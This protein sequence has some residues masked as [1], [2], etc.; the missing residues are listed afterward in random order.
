MKDKKIGIILPT[1]GMVF[2]RVEEEIEKLRKDY[3]IEVYRSHDLPIP[4]GHNYLTEKALGDG[5]EVLFYIEEDNVP[6]TGALEKLLA[7][8]KDADIACID[9]GVSGWGCVTR[10][11][12]GEILWCGL[13]TTLIKRQVFETLERPYFRV[14]KVLRQNDWKWIDLPEDYIKTKQYGSLDIWFCCQARA[15]GFKIVQVDGEE[16]TH[17]QLDKL[18]ERGTNHGCHL[19]SE[20]PK[21]EKRQVLNYEGN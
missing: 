13:G 2:T 15:K 19:I 3:D 6:P 12:K 18:G 9:Y 16:S 5:K 1:R 8:T 17:L 7:V 4:E 20:R 14:D 11:I 21:I 10:N